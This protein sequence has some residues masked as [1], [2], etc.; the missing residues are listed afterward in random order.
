M[1]THS[2]MPEAEILTES[3]RYSCDIPGQSLAYK[4]GDT[5][6]LSLRERMRSALGSRFALKDFHTA[7]L[8][9]GALPLQELEWHVEHEI[10]RLS[11]GV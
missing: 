1:R 11:G 10:Q 3:V 4:L 8:G 6:I 9:S 5:H 7:I 2:G